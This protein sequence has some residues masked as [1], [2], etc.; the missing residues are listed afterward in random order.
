M[1][2]CIGTTEHVLVS[3]Q[4]NWTRCVWD[5]GVITTAAVFDVKLAAIAAK[6]SKAQLDA[7]EALALP[8]A[9]GILKT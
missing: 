6:Y 7:N 3:Y 1:R 9:I 2:A 5:C 8:I 4:S